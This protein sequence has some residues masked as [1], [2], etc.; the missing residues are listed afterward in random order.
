M[1]VS[2]NFP[3]IAPSLSLDFANVKALDSRITFTRASSARYYNGVT[4]AKAE[5]NLVSYSNFSSFAGTTWQ[6]DNGTT[7]VSQTG[8]DSSANAVLYKEDT[9]NTAHRIRAGSSITFSAAA[10]TSFVLSVFA[11]YVSRDYVYIGI[12]PTF[13]NS[14]VAE[15]NI[16]TGAFTRQNAAGTLSII[17]TPSITSAGGGWYRMSMVCSSTAAISVIMTFGTS[18]GTTAIDSNQGTIP[19]TGTE[20][21]A[22]FFG[23]QGEQRSSVTA[24]TPTTT[25]PITNYIPT[26]LTATDNVARFDHNPIT[27]ESLGLLIEELRTNL[28]LRSEEFDDASW[29]KTNATVTANTIVAPDGTLTGDELVENT[30]FGNHL[31][32]QSLT[33][34]ASAITYTISCYLKS[35]KS[36]ARLLLDGGTN[37]NKVQ[38]SFDLTLGTIS[39]GAQSAGT[40][41]SPVASISSVGNG[42]YR[43]I[44]TGTTGTETTLRSRIWLLDDVS[45]TYTGD[46]YSGIYIWGA[47]LE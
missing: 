35:S 21:E 45:D 1:S 3:N 12:R 4:T 47:Q 33:K 37:T 40:F 5:E 18:D 38:V 22:L 14:A 24:Y 28:L 10:N 34:A 41:S 6:S 27:G 25:Q 39:V 7:T 36:G 42:W 11:K 32:T 31:V 30:S 29:V 44:L 17:G 8:P 15:F 26:L 19:F 43:C 9:T 16:N 20:A 23:P 46:G 13:G 2:Q